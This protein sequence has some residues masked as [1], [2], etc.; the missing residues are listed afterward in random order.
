MPTIVHAYDTYT[1][2]RAVFTLRAK[3][4][5]PRHLSLAPK[6]TCEVLFLSLSHTS[7]QQSLNIKIIHCAT[8]FIQDVISPGQAL[9][10]FF[11]WPRAPGSTLGTKPPVIHG[12]ISSGHVHRLCPPSRNKPGNSFV[13][14]VNQY[15][16]KCQQSIQAWINTASFPN[17]NSTN[18]N[19]KRFCSNPDRYSNCS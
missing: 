16:D 6:C 8:D 3:F 5:Y 2:R 10:P 17:Q 15:T 12:L 11:T 19:D 14:C 7:H 18:T 4:T 13:S 1:H 9:N